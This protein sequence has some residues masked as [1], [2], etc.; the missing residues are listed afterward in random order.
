MSP[1]GNYIVSAGIE[2]NLCM[3]SGGSAQKCCDDGNAKLKGRPAQQRVVHPLIQAK[4]KTGLALYFLVLGLSPPDIKIQGND[5][6]VNESDHV[7]RRAAPPANSSSLIRW[8]RLLSSTH[9]GTRP[10]NVSQPFE[11]QSRH[12]NINFKLFSGGH[13]MCTVDVP[14]AQDEN[15]IDIV[16]ESDAEAAAVMQRTNSNQADSSTQLGQP[17]GARPSQAPIQ[18]E[19]LVSID[20]AEDFVYAGVSCCCGFFFGLR[21]PAPH[22][23]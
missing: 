10:L 2:K 13:S 7:S 8:R 21:R 23:S 12:W 4:K 5:F 19:A 9:F 1:D 18:T 22:R 3:D 11:R 6:F 17:T 14:L 20:G 16:P 15:R